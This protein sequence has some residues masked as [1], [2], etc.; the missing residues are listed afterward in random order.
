MRREMSTRFS[1]RGGWPGWF[2]GW[3]A[4]MR[5]TG[6]NEWGIRDDTEVAGKDACVLGV[7]SL[8]REYSQL[9][10]LLEHCR[11]GSGT[12]PATCIAEF[13]SLKVGMALGTPGSRARAVLE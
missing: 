12:T 13:G 10:V 7:V 5:L 2:G 4:R 6:G 8:K 9:F 11:A 1:G 3:I